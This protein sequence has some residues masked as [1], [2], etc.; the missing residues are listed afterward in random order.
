M[1]LSACFFHLSQS[2]YRKIQAEG[3]Q[4]HYN[5][6]ADDFIGKYTHMILALA[7]VP[8]D[9]VSAAFTLLKNDAPL[10]LVNFLDYFNLNYVNGRRAQCIK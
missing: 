10:K 7:F 2:V 5:D 4:V 3:L 1:P 9:D 8:L 6:P